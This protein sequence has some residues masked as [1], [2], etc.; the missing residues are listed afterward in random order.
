MIAPLGLLA[1]VVGVLGHAVTGWADLEVMAWSGL[2]VY[3][4]GT[5]RGIPGRGLSYI[6]IALALA[7]VAL[8]LLPAPAE[9]YATALRRAAFVTTLFTALGFLREAA[10][11]SGMVHRCGRFLSEQPPGRRYSALT[12]GSHLF[13]LILNFGVISLLGAMVLAACRGRPGDDPARAALREQRMLTAVLRGFAAILAWSPLTVS[14]AVILT[15]L[16][17]TEWTAVGPWCLGTAILLLGWGWVQDRRIRPP[18]GMAPAPPAA[19]VEGGWG[20][21][22]PVIALVSGIFTLG[23]LVEE[24]L[25]VQLVV[26]VMIATPVIGAVWIFVQQPGKRSVGSIAAASRTTGARL[27]AHARRVF[28]GYRMEVALLASAAFIG[29]VIAVLLPEDTI[30][31]ALAAAPVPPWVLLAVLAW[32]VVALGQVGFNPVMSVTIASGALPAPAVLGVP[33][34]AVAVALAG[35]WALTANTSPFTAALLGIA[36]MTGNDPGRIGRRWNGGYALVGL[37]LLSAWI[38]IVAQLAG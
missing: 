8:L 13:G 14:M 35:A 30:A 4:L 37:L 17:G 24:V 19:P 6:T 2:G 33:A 21:T 27:V 1:V 29:S 31:A 36:Q 25:D 38:G 20:L 3:L 22:L 16:P 9:T 15:S 26:G 10:E 12:S 7:A 11:T 34:E 32:V 18:R 5:L 23:W 28:P